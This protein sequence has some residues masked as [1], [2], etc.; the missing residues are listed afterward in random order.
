MVAE[1]TVVDARVIGA[2]AIGAG[3]PGLGPQVLRGVRQER[4]VACALEC[5]RQ[6]SLV[7]RAGSGLSTRLDLRALREVAPEAVDLL[8]VDA[9]RLVDAEVADLPAPSVAVVVRRLAAGSG[10]R[11]VLI[12]SP[13]DQNGMSSTSISVPGAD[14][15]GAAPRGFTAGGASSAASAYP[16]SSRGR[17]SRLTTRAKRSSR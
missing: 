10:A 2:P 14:D 11:H 16:P 8:V 5:R 15:R 1:Q 3:N 17:R 4:D 7:T 13:S 12:G 9:L 6:H